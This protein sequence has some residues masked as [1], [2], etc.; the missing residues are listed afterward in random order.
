MYKLFFTDGIQTVDNVSP[1]TD[2]IFILNNAPFT[3]E[4]KEKL[5]EQIT[6]GADSITYSDETTLLMVDKVKENG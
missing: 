1:L 6:S 5:I 4:D 3:E 2:V